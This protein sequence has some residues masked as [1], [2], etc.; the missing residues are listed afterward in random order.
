VTTPV[1]ARQP[2]AWKTFL[3]HRRAVKLEQVEM[4]ADHCVVFEREDG[5]QHLRVIDLRG[6]ESHRVEFGEPVYV[7]AAGANAEFDTDRF[8]F[9]YQSLVTPPSVLDYEMGTRR[10][11]LLRR[12]EVGGGYEPAR[13]TSERLFA[14]ARDG[15]RIPVSLVYRKGRRRDGRSPML[16]VGYGAYGVAA[17]AAFS[18]AR[19]SLLDRGVVYAVAHVR[20]GGEMGEEW[21]EAGRLRSKRNSFTDFISV[22]EHLIAGKYTS[23]ARLAIQGDSAGGLLVG[24]VLNMRPELFRAAVLQVPFVDVLTAMLDETLPLTAAEYPEWGDPRDPRAYAYMK[25]YSPY[26]NIRAA[27]YPAVLVKTSLHDSLVMF[28]GPVKYVARLRATKTDARPLL[29][30]VNLGAGHGGPAGRYD[31]LRELAFDYAF[32][33]DQLGKRR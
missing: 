2:A 13:Y 3:P 25:S 14:A 23:P 32:V 28:W 10:R 6:G 11:T 33:L 15:T 5:L 29:C 8:R 9:R 16:L 7:V 17:P 18:S 1:S 19:L 30:R 20:G 27:S 26:E 24:A 21:H 12:A 31:A 4:L 22:A